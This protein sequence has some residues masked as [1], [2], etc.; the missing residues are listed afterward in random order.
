MN[1]K[2]KDMSKFCSILA[3][4]SL[5]LLAFGGCKKMDETYKGF[6]VPGGIVYPGKVLGARAYSG[7]NRIGLS[8]HRSSDPSV[9]KARVYWNDHADSVE[10]DMPAGQDSVG[11]II[12]NLAEQSYVFHIVTLDGEG[13]MSV[14]VEVLSASYGDKYQASLLNRPVNSSLIAASGDS[15]VVEWGAANI[16]GGAFATQLRFTDTTGEEHQLSVAADDDHTVLQGMAS[17]SSFQFRTV[18]LPD[19]MSIDT[20]YTPYEENA[21]FQLDKS[22]WQ[23]VSFSTEHPGA[24]NLASNVIDGNPGTR[25]HTWVDHSQY[26][27]FVTVDMG[28]SRTIAAFRIYR[29]KDDDRGCD[30]FQL[31]VSEDGT[32]WTDL[33]VFPF[34]R[35]TNEGQVYPIASMPQARYW[36]FTGLSGPLAYMVTGEIDVFGR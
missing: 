35:L 4:A 29:M 28:V 2:H 32:T 18:Y 24:A 7:H 34:N 11:V 21:Q 1:T 6:I 33:G 27:H 9:Q 14:P 25:W 23:V 30:S 8:W 10:V 5:F 26:P 17:G 19:S 12:D 16:S 36:R 13:H 20:F 15:V 3:A 22:G 31:E